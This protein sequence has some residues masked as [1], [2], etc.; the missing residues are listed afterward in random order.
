MNKKQ[1]AVVITSKQ[2]AELLPVC[3]IMP[4]AEDE[5]RGRT[6]CTLISAGTELS[7]A[8]S[9]NTFPSYPGYSA[10]FVVEEVGTV[11]RDVKIG[12]RLFCQGSHR[13]F[14]QESIAKCV[15]V[16]STLASEKA[17]FA[18]MMGISMTTLATT[19]AKPPETVVVTGLG[20]VGLMAALTFQAC[21]YDVIGCE[22]EKQRRQWANNAGLHT[23]YER[24]PTDDQAIIGKVGLVVECSGHESAVL[25][26]CKV[27]RKRGEIVLVGV[28]WRRRT[29]YYAHELLSLVFH[30]YAVLR[31]GWEWELPLH[32]SDFH[33]HSIFGNYVAAI[34]WLSE[35]RINVTG[36]FAEVSPSDAQSVYQGLLNNITASL[37]VVFNW[38]SI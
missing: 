12:D 35:A 36:L 6:L 26:A 20:P 31:S 9:G 34:K 28:P 38:E 13:S 4:L 16:P 23:L 29:E 25:D 18:R 1:Y 27:I 19:A 37:C 15:P 17:L 8:Y 7:W 22:P 2:N 5:V 24:I 21:G 14:Q 11:V 32:T 3:D 10:V 33:P 30:K